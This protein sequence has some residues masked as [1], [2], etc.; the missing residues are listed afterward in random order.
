MTRIIRML[1]IRRY[2]PLCQFLL[3]LY[4]CKDI[5]QELIDTANIF[6]NIHFWVVA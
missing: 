6:T 3:C 1:E 4:L 2:L 5:L